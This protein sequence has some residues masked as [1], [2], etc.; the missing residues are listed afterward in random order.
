MELKVYQIQ[1]YLKH[2]WF[3]SHLY[4]IERIYYMMVANSVPTFQSHLYGIESGV[5]F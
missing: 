2:L 1:R 4:G 3:Q 5:I